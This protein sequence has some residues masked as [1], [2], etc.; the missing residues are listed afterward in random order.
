MPYKISHTKITCYTFCS[1]GTSLLVARTL[2]YIK[3]N[4]K[5]LH[6]RSASKITTM[7]KNECENLMYSVQ[8]QIV[9]NAQQYVTVRNS[10]IINKI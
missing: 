7:N 10:A 6:L 5:L 8:C 1:P 2:G 9:R 4:K 3:C